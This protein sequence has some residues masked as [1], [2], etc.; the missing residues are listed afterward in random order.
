M[1]LKVA[2]KTLGCKLNQAETEAV[3]AGF[4][5]LGWNIVDFGSGA[6]VVVVNG[7]T[8]TNT[9]D[10]KSRSAMN[11]AFRTLENPAK[12]LVVMTGCFVDGNREQLEADG[13]TYLVG[14]SD[15]N[16]IP[17]LVDAHIRGELLPGH[18]ESR[19]DPFGFP[20]TEPVFRTRAMVKVQDGCD[21]FCSFCIIPYVR[22]RAV[23]EP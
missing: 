15:K 1:E 2:F 4:R 14:N 8:V 21:N 10:S 20:L 23:A 18:L 6:D 13:R 7:C 5:Q 19:R 9:A 17:Q 12:G 3:A 11:Q 22:G 16:L